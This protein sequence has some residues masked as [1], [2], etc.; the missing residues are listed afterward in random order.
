MIDANV[1]SG[2]RFFFHVYFFL[3]ALGIASSLPEGIPHGYI[4]VSCG[5]WVEIKPRPATPL[6][7]WAAK[8]I[9]W[10]VA[11]GAAVIPFVPPLHPLRY[12]LPGAW[13]IGTFPVVL[14][15]LVRRNATPGK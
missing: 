7:R 13:V 2:L 9:A 6:E 1:V 14:F 12:W 3:L 4:R 11:V 10:P 15:A 8:W 5:H